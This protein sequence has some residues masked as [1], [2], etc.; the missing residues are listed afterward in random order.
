MK[1]DRK[2][3]GYGGGFTDVRT[4]RPRCRAEAVLPRDRGP[5]QR[6]VAAKKDAR[7]KLQLRTGASNCGQQMTDDSLA[8]LPRWK[9]WGLYAI[10]GLTLSGVAPMALAALL[11]WLC[12]M[13]I[14]WLE[15]LIGSGGMLALG[16]GT[17]FA[18]LVGCMAYLL[19]LV[20][21]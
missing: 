20:A 11:S 10:A 3:V 8:H 6:M 5:R 15:S 1:T 19:R 17:C 9:R 21:R 12:D 14:A 13:L 4:V 2:T 7:P 18:G 16:L